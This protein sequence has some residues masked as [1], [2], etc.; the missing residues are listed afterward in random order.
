MM[1]NKCIT[2]MMARGMLATVIIIMKIMAA[3]T[4]VMM[5]VGIVKRVR[6]MLTA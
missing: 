4:R 2:T 5:V 1:S 3:F 6:V